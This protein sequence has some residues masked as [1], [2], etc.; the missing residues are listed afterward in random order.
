MS[1]MKAQ[2]TFRAKHVSVFRST[3]QWCV[4]VLVMLPIGSACAQDPYKAATSGPRL[5]AL[6]PEVAK[7]LSFDGREPAVVF[8]LDQDGRITALT[9]TGKPLPNRSVEFP[10]G[11]DE[12]AWTQS[13][14]VFKYKNP[15]I[16]VIGLGWQFCP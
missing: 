8:V 7:A 5:E 16:C 4:L 10:R 14:T 13:I 15:S 11:P 6:P 2:V 1:P 12:I 3:L 9:G